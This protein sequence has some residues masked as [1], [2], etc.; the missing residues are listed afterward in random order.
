MKT[1]ILILMLGVTTTF[2][3]SAQNK[4]QNT[5]FLP[6]SAQSPS[7]SIDEVSW[8]QGH[9]T[10]EAFGGICEEIWSPP[11]AGS[12]MFSFRL[13]NDN[14]VSFYEFGDISEEEG[15]LVLRLKHFHPDLKGWEE[16]NESVSFK[17]VKIEKDKCYFNGFTFEKISNH[18]INLYVVIGHGEENEEVK[19]NYKRVK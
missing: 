10:G 8:I 7:A 13:I 6:D 4:F 15:S 9:W 11:A 18:E 3:L 16:K 2:S 17:L 5:L 1:F 12:M 19:F 14:E